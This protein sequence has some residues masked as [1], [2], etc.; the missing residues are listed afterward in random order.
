MGQV[1]WYISLISALKRL[2]QK[3]GEFED[4]LGNIGR[5]CLKKTKQQEWVGDVVLW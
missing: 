2:R 3:D 1:W 5:P 4:N